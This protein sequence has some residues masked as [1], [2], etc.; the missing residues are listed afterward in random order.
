M[1]VAGDPCSFVKAYI[2]INFFLKAELCSGVAPFWQKSTQEFPQNAAN[3][4]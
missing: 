1:C 4:I 3:L 2:F